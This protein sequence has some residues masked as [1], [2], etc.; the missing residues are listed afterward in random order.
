MN[1]ALYLTNIQN[2]CKVFFNTFNTSRDT[3]F[4]L[5]SGKIRIHT[6][7]SK[8]DFIIEAMLDSIIIDNIIA[9]NLN[10]KQIYSLSNYQ[11]YNI[12]KKMNYFGNCL[13][14]FEETQCCFSYQHKNKKTRFIIQTTKIESIYSIPTTIYSCIFT[15]V[16]SDFILLIN[17]CFVIDTDVELSIND[18]KLI[19]NSR[20]SNISY[21]TQI[22]VVLYKYSHFQFVYSKDHLSL[23]TNYSEKILYIKVYVDDFGLIK[24]SMYVHYLGTINFYLSPIL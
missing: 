8:K 24:I 20:D 16:P 23:I 11:L 14:E 4:I 1:V 18:N 3:N 21:K 6:V 12:T 15:I 13:F 7:S 22:P 2:L 5:E 10:Q 19:A 9:P 17:R